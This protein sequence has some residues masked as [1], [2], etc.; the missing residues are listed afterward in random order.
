MTRRRHGRQ[1]SVLELIAGAPWPVGVILGV[2]GFVL[3][4]YGIGWAASQSEN[5]YL[6][7][8][9]AGFRDGSLAPLAWVCL[10]VCWFAACISIVLGRISQRQERPARRKTTPRRAPQWEMDTPPS[11]GVR[12]GPPSH[13]PAAGSAVSA[14]GPSPA[15]V[16]RRNIADLSWL[17]FEH[18]IAASFRAKG[19]S[20]ELTCE[21][22]DEGI[23]IVLRER[24]NVLIVQCKHWLCQRVDVATVRELYGVMHAKNARKAILATSHRLTAE[25][26]R[27]C[28]T[29]AI[30]CIDA[31]NL[32]AFIDP[33]AM[34]A[35]ADINAERQSRCPLCGAGMVRRVAHK[36]KQPFFGCSRYPTCRGKRFAH[37]CH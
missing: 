17:Q 16:T 15:P 35:Q 36:S 33:A 2:L 6:V 21:G 9:T 23:D 11:A 26:Q 1:E 13:G 27:F 32:M 20:A 34:P 12:A 28:Q 4:R 22:A 18:L 30:Y 25:A 37:A 5:P 31:D 7:A 10:G 19:F 3:V 29:N 24:D 8:L 14:E